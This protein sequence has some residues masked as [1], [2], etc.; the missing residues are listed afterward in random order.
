[1]RP[2]YSS[3][4]RGARL[5]ALLLALIAP[6]GRAECEC[7]WEGSF[8]D[9]Q[10][11]TDLVIAASV[12]RIKGNAVDLHVEQNLRGDAFFDEIRI[13]LRTRDYCRPEVD[14]FP[15]GSRWVLALHRID[16]VPED[17]FDPGTPNLSY[18]RRGD[19]YLSN[20]GG[21]WLN[22][23]GEAVTGNLIDAPRWAR[24][25]DMQPVLLSLLEAYLQGRAD[26]DALREA[27]REDPALDNLMLDTRA[28]LRGDGIIEQ[29]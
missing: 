7:L 25:V 24:D 14:E 8:A 6:P 26:R 12:A 23:S 18:G 2:A 4:W 20:C 19:Y 1:M 17:G 5:A 29:P 11:G 21:Y 16:E 10:G 27:A 22:Y 3:S 13:W 28:F 15:V 9:V